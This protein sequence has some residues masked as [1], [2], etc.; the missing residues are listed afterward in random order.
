MAKEKEQDVSGFKL[1][2]KAARYDSRTLKLGNYLSL[3]RL[4]TP[5]EEV[6]YAK[7]TKYTMLGNDRMGNCAIVGP[8]HVEATWT[9]NDEPYKQYEPSLQEVTKAY[10]AV[11]GYNPRTGANDNGCVLLDVMKYWR[12]NGIGRSKITAFAS[13]NV[14]DHEEMCAAHYL[15]GG[16][17]LGLN[18]PAAWK[19][20]DVWRAPSGFHLWGQWQPNSWGGHC[21][22]TS[23]YDPLMMTTVTW[24]A[25][26]KISYNAL[27]K[28]C[29]EAFVAIGPSW[30]GADNR[31]PTGFDLESMVRDL[32]LLQ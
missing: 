32:R 10:S 29:S 3:T 22:I 24:G 4:K 25:L 19:K 20:M 31:A 6:D 15:F 18:M 28:Y 8:A 2:L 26:K 27:N 14:N 9:A 17:I 7:K 16:L 1:G 30:F 13:V 12:R 23:G 21:V 11:S 5:P